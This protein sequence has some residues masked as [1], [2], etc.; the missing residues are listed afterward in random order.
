M[1]DHLKITPAGIHMMHDFEGCVLYAYQCPAKIW[2]I[3]FG[4]TFYENNTPVQKGD[5][6]TQERANEL[7]ALIVARFEAQVKKVVTVPL[8]AN[9]FS[10]LVSFAY[11]CGIAN[12]KSST[13]LKKVNANPADGSIRNEFLKWNKAGGKVLSGLTRRRTAEANLYFS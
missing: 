8:T 11:N 2:T 7:F 6:I 1:N 12:L 10:A 5:K 3:G 13:L 9:Q 4:N